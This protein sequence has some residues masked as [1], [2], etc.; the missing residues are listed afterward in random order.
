MLLKNH[1]VNRLLNDKEFIVEVVSHHLEHAE[2]ASLGVEDG[3]IALLRAENNKTYL[4]TKS[5]TDKLEL[6]DTKKAMDIEGWKVFKDLPDFKKTF[7]LPNTDQNTSN[8]LRVLKSNGLLYFCHFGMTPDK[9]R[10]NWGNLYWVLLFVDL[11]NNRMAEYFH[12]KDGNALAPFLYALMC[13]TQLTDN[14]EILL[15]HGRKYGTIKQGKVINTLQ[16]PITIVNSKWNVTTIRTEGFPVRGHAR[17][18]PTKDGIK[19]I[20]IEPFMKTGY[21][22]RSG[23]ELEK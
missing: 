6:F 17:L 7:I 2:H 21:T 22:R 1:I 11:D 4:V 15:E 8:C 5:V 12:S 13:F 9:T 19:L 10:D 16:Q 3:M 18:Q 23:K 14:E 20:Y